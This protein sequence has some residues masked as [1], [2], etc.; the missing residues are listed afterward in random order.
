MSQLNAAVS[1]FLSFK[2]FVML[3]VI[4]LILAPFSASN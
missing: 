4:I 3:P 2:V 1:Y